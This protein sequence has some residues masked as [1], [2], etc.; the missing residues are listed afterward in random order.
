MSVDRRRF[1]FHKAQKIAAA[2][3][4][5]FMLQSLWLLAHL[6]LDMAETRNALAGEALWSS[7]PLLNSESPLIPG[8][9]VL[10]LRCA[11]L[12]PAI[13]KHWASSGQEFSIYAAPSRWLV[14]LPFVVF[15]TWL[16]GA[17]WWVARR[18]FGDQ[19]GYVA[20]GLYCFSPPALIASA[21]VDSAV[22]AS[23]GLFGL[24]FTA[25]GV[26]HTLYAPPHKWRPRIVLL[27]VAIGLTAAANVVAAI[28]GLVL[29][30]V[31]MLYLA[32]GRRLASLGIL[33]ISSL[34]GCVILLWCFGFRIHD[35][36]AAAL[37][38]NSDYFVP[39]SHHLTSF[40]AI[41]GGLLEAVAFL[42]ALLV[43]LTWKRTRYFG[44][45]APLISALVL[46]WWIGAFAPGSSIIWALPFAFVFVGGIYADLLE[47]SFFAGRF[48]RL[49]V[50]TA[51]V[52]V[53]ASAV[54]SIMVTTSS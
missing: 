29:A 11:G 19:G 8:D 32:P 44:N 40:L 26:A 33:V 48:R 41:P 39:T 54:F 7:R 27:G 46:P 36:R 28:A 24:V 30:A 5:A 49:V 9:S 21:S 6:P 25:I 52:L 17:L 2:L 15:G 45:A 13:A 16:G 51:F 14:R 1:E 53:G 10:A 34:I 12:F 4:L 18:L 31:F 38:P 47:Q 37:V 20:L 23:W 35:I 50:P 22:L 43:F 3:L 42:A